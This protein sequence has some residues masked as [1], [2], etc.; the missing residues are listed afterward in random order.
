[1]DVEKR[2]QIFSQYIDQYTSVVC[3]TLKSLRNHK[4]DLRIPYAQ[5]LFSLIDYYGLLYRVAA[6]NK[7]NKRDKNNFLRF[8]SSVYFPESDRCKASILY[9]FRNGIIHQI[10]PKACGIGC[11][12]TNSLFFRDSHDPSLLVLN[13]TYLDNIIVKAVEQFELDLKINKTYIENLYKSLIVDHYGLGDH[14]ELAQEVNTS[15]E[16]DF[17]NIYKDCR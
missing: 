6:D 1:M 3:N 14:D 12:L 2:Q 15:Y 4:N 8:V 17:E 5:F 16:G 7:Y 13:L 11:S 10:F 9:F